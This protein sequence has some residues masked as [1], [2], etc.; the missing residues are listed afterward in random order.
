M[1]SDMTPAQLS[2]FIQEKDLDGQSMVLKA[3]PW[4]GPRGPAGLGRGEYNA[5]DR[6]SRARVGSCARFDC[7]A[8]HYQEE[9]WECQ[10][11]GSQSF[12][13]VENCP[14]GALRCKDT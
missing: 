1:L 12:W 10:G 6:P 7:F 14:S 11:D 13:C 9:R 8:I 4:T 2:R 5:S 3:Y